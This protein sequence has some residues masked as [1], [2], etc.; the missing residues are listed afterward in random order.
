MDCS[1]QSPQTWT[2]TAPCLAGAVRRKQQFSGGARKFQLNAMPEPAAIGEIP[3]FC[4]A[5]VGR[6]LLGVDPVF[7]R[8]SIDHC[9]HGCAACFPSPTDVN[10][11]VTGI[12]GAVQGKD[13]VRAWQ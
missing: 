6:C 12:V 9:R 2:A 1:C 10:D 3:G 11:L 13:E 4:A 8:G 5:Q 7:C